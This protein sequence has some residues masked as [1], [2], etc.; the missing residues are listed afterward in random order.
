MSNPCA[1]CGRCCREYVVPLSGH[2]VWRITRGQRL[3]THEFV[4]AA[5]QPS[6][7]RDTFRL[8]RGG[9]Q[10]GLVLDKRG[11]FDLGASCVFLMELGGGQSRCGI[12]ADRPLACQIYPTIMTRTRDLGVRVEQREGTI[13]PPDSWS[14]EDFASSP[15][16]EAH[17]R[18]RRHWDVYL[19][20]VNRWNARIDL[21]P[22]GTRASIGDYMIYLENVYASIEALDATYTDDERAEVART[23]RT[24]PPAGSDAPPAWVRYFHAVRR[25]IDR[26]FPEVQPLPLM[27]LAADAPVGEMR[28]AP[29]S[30]PA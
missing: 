5:T 21:M 8:E 11:K 24:M 17:Q 25:L 30:P 1:T 22:E 7:D 28:G 27:V 15:W 4:L 6:G 16:L 18:L 14:P 13:C 10:L 19:E 9:E 3:P 26:I 2:D 20:V 23:W 12:Y 29:A